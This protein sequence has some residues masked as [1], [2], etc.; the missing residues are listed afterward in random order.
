ML[1]ALLQRASSVPETQQ[2][3]LLQKCLKAVLPVCNGQ[4]SAGDICS[5]GVETALKK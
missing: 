3:E 1:Q 4:V 2:P 5:S